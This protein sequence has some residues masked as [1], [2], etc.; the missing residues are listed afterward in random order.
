MSGNTVPHAHFFPARRH[1]DIQR[2]LGMAYASAEANAVSDLRARP[3]SAAAAAEPRVFRPTDY[4]ADP[5]GASDSFHALNRTVTVMLGAVLSDPT[6]V[7]MGDLGGAVL[8]LSGGRYAVSQG[9]VVPAGKQRES[10][11]KVRA[12]ASCGDGV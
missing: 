12:T 10:Q 4:G 11:S 9:L 7:A 8:D 2:T 1:A 3:S 5:T 6:A